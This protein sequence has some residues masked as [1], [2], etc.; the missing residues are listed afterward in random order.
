MIYILQGANAIDLKKTNICVKRSLH[1]GYLSSGNMDNFSSY[2]V[3]L[4]ELFNFD[5]G[6]HCEFVIF[7]SDCVSM[8]FKQ[9]LV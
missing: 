9:L 1:S 3:K 6:K 8:C 4:D 7:H 2:L 5:L